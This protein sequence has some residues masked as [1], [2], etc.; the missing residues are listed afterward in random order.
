ME[1]VIPVVVLV[2]AIAGFVT[3]MVLNATRRSTPVAER[4]PEPDAARR[5]AP[6]ERERPASERLADRDV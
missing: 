4:D 6:G 2:L 1:Y 3:F 5:G